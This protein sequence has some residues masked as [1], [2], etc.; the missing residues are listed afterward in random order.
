M[1]DN[2]L[3]TEVELAYEVM[4]C[5]ALR[6]AQEPGKD[7]HPCSYFRKWGDYHSYDYPTIGP[8]Q[9]GKVVNLPQ[10]VYVGRAP[11]VP[12]MVSGCRKAPIMAVGINPNL[13]GWFAASYNS[14]YP[15]FDDYKQFAHYFRY[16][17]TQK[18]DIPKDEFAKYSAAHEG[19]LTQT[20]PPRPNTNGL[21]V[22]TD[23]HGDRTIPAEPLDVKMYESY[24]SLLSDLAEKMGWQN[25]SLSLGEDVSYGNMVACP[26]AKWLNAKDDQNP[27][28]PPMTA[29]EQRGIVNECFHIRRYF[30]RQLFQ[31]LPAVLMV[32]SQNTANAFIGEMSGRFSAGNPKVGEKI[33]DLIQRTVRLKYGTAEDG[34][35]MEARVIFSP[36]ITGDPAHFQATRQRVLA[37][38]IE[39]AQAGHIQFNPQ[40]KHLSRPRGSCVFCTMLT[41]GPCDYVDEIKPLKSAPELLAASPSAD[42]KGDKDE[43]Q[44]LLGEFLAAGQLAPAE[45]ALLA[46]APAPASMPVTADAAQGWLLSGDP[47]EG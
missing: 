4:P 9:Q 33:D 16:R 17:R 15:W 43:Q 29:N 5:N 24:E 13:T 22:P 3:P 34:S 41:I 35:P 10:Y 45:A 1:S 46:A 21:D 47:K 39:E 37:Q 14:I 6:V 28:M 25:H 8:P 20:N 18:L 23:G 38:L 2:H 31:S 40:T 11:L 42:V 30:L 19:P 44:R 12:E 7:P 32:F 36:H 27:D 26:S